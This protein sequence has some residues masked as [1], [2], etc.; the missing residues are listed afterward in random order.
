VSGRIE[1][2]WPLFF[3]RDIDRS[4]TFYRD[5]LGFEL[6]GRAT[7]EH[8]IFWCRLARDGACVMLQQIDGDRKLVPSPDVHYFVCDDADLIYE[9]LTERGLELEPPSVAYY[10]MK[11][12]SVPE[13]DGRHIVFES[14]TEQWSE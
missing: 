10:G 4:I 7:S 6:I 9:E 1:Q 2:L 5:S 14:R 12:V 11:Q 8:G 3:V 13:P